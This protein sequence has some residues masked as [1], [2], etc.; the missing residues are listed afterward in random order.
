MVNFYLVRRPKLNPTPALT[1]P[2]PDL[3]PLEARGPQRRVARLRRVIRWRF[4][5]KKGRPIGHP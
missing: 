3:N 1:H 4:P 5:K 2:N